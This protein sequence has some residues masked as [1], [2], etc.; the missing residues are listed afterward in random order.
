MFTWRCKA[1]PKIHLSLSAAQ[2]ELGRKA[3][4]PLS[5]GEG[6][7]VVRKFFL[8]WQAVSV[9][10]ACKSAAEF[11]KTP[12]FLQSDF[13]CWFQPVPSDQLRQTKRQTSKSQKCSQS[14]H[15]FPITVPPVTVQISSK[16]VNKSSFSSKTG[17]SF[18][19]FGGS[20]GVWHVKGS[21]NQ[22]TPSRN[23]I[24]ERTKVLE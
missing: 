5:L 21:F 17:P 9:S 20:L 3:A 18:L 15:P 1:E 6:T 10:F 11:F 2:D 12:A 7:E 19:Q 22:C 13:P 23:W 16:R 4:L 14:V 24:L 8:G